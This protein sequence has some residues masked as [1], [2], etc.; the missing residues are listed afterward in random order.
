MHDHLTNTIEKAGQVR[1]YVQIPEKLFTGFICNREVEEVDYF[2]GSSS[3]VKCTGDTFEVITRVK[4]Y[5]GLL[6]N[7]Q[8]I[9]MQRP[10]FA[11]RKCGAVHDIQ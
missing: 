3:M 2:D 8:T 10:A 1:D 11:C 6:S 4:T 5:R 7:G 9:I